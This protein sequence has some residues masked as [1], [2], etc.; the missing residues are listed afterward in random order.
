MMPQKR[1]AF[2]LENI[3]G[4]AAGPAGALTAL[5]LGMKNT[6]FGNTLEVGSEATAHLWPALGGV[7]TAV[8]LTELMLNEIEI[9]ADR[10][11]R[12]LDSGETTMTALA[13]H[14]VARHGL[15][16]RTAHEVVGHLLQRLPR[17][18]PRSAA[19]VRADLEATL[20]EV[21]GIAIAMDESGSP[22]LAGSARLHRGRTPWR[23]TGAGVGP[24][25]TDEPGRSAPGPRRAC[26]RS[27][28]AARRSRGAPRTSRD[29]SIE[30]LKMRKAN[31]VLELMKDSP[32]VALRGRAA[33][34]PRWGASLGEARADAS[35]SHEGPGGPWRSSSGPRPPASCALEE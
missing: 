1:N 9:D 17:A 11:R 24:R 3:R 7:R 8:Q 10:M 15:S 19:T 33:S 35:R 23:R 27:Q 30:H 16:F 12:F 25:S 34:K 5:L 26:R 4:Q 29:L 21:T 14:L 22:W 13:D 28:P 20:L 32:L 2:V 18:E 31:S 6:P